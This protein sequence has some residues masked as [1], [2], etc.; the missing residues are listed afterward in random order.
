MTRF[1]MPGTR[2]RFFASPVPTPPSRFHLHR[3]P[4]SQALSTT[5]AFRHRCHS[6]AR[7]TGDP[8]TH[9]PPRLARRG[10]ISEFATLR[11]IAEG[12]PRSFPFH[13][14]AVRFESPIFGEA[15]PL[16]LAAAGMAAGVAVGD[17][18]WVNG[19]MRSL[20]ALA[21][22]DADP[23]ATSLPPLPAPVASIL[24]ACGKARSVAQLPQSNPPS[25]APATP[26]TSLNIQAADAIVRDYRARLDEIAGLAA[27]PHDLPPAE[28]ARRNTRLGETTGPKNPS[29]RAPS[30]LLAMIAWPAAAH[31]RCA[32]VLPPI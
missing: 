18:W 20:S 26:Q 10:R 16:G 2:S 15:L 4:R 3:G 7:W 29:S 13:N 32:A 12:V 30:S 9:Q 11:A 1:A 5:R 27:L 6:V 8:C 28:E 19:R 17:A 24:A 23:K 22:V 21:V 25:E 14:V 31:S